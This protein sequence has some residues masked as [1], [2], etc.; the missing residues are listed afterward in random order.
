MNP[1]DEKVS[2]PMY[3]LDDYENWCQPLYTNGYENTDPNGSGY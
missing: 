2:P 3:E 1:G